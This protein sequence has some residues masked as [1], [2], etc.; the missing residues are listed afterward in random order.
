[1]NIVDKRLNY[2]LIVGQIFLEPLFVYT[3]YL[4]CVYKDENHAVFYVRILLDFKM[5]YI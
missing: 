5:S 2:F 3:D 1:M 4:I